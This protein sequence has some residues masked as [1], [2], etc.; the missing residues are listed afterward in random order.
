MVGAK[1]GNLMKNKVLASSIAAALL[2]WTVS[3]ANAVGSGEI[4]LQGSNHESVVYTYSAIEINSSGGV[5]VVLKDPIDAPSD[6]G[7]GSDGNDDGSG[8]DGNDGSGSDGNDDGSGS[9][10][11]NDGSGDDGELSA[12][13]G[14]S[15]VDLNWTGDVSNTLFD[16]S[17]SDV[18][19]FKMTTSNDGEYRSF[20]TYQRASPP[21]VRTIWVS[22]SPGVVDHVSRDSRSCRNENGHETSMQ[23]DTGTGSRIAPWRCQLDNNKTYYINVKAAE[24]NSLNDSTC[25]SGR[26]CLFTRSFRAP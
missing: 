8:S 18:I 11:N 1:K 24:W 19:S 2:T 13:D 21:A 5:N 14:V 22:E 3:P 17:Q 6:D 9:G 26:G 7:G 15:V 16:L 23:I 4:T 10:G 25:V 20:S 12:P